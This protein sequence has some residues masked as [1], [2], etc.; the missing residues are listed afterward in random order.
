MILKLQ[1]KN[2]LRG[3]V[4]CPT[5]GHFTGI[6]INVKDD[7]EFLIKGKDYY[8]DDFCNNNEI[9]IIEKNYLDY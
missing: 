8:Y 3:I 4:S 9:L 5:A 6:L 1:I 7:I 2:F